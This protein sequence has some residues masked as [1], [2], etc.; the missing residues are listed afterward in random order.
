[1]TEREER[2]QRIFDLLVDDK[3]VAQEAFDSIYARF[4]PMLE[5]SASSDDGQRVD[6]VLSMVTPGIASV[7]RWLMSNHDMTHKGA[8]DIVT[9]ATVLLLLSIEDINMRFHADEP[10]FDTE[11][12]KDPYVIARKL[13]LTI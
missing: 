12:A 8:Q 10:A 9:A 4:K 7:V 13:G 3:V 6:A 1:M 2:T 11:R 5:L